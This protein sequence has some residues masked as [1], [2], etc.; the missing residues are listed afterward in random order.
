MFQMRAE[1]IGGAVV[2][3]TFTS[4]NKRLMPGTTL[5]REEV[6]AF[7]TLNRNSLAEKR[8]IDLFPKNNNAPTTTKAER[9]VVNAGFGHY[10]VIEG[11]K[12]TDEPVDRE[13]AYA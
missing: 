1:E 5:T 11:K 8:Y 3:R 4:G 10:H 6:L 12:L 13:Q 2:R 7:P 9:F